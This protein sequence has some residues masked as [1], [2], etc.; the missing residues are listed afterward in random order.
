MTSG[1]LSGSCPGLKAEQADGA[2]GL[3]PLNVVKLVRSS[4]AGIACWKEVWR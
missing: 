4:D 1:W 2:Y 3:M